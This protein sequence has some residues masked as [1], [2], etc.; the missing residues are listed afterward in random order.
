[1]IKHPSFTERLLTDRKWQIGI[2]L[3]VVLGGYYL[4]TKFGANEPIIAS[5][6]PVTVS[7][8]VK[9]NVPIYMELVGQTIGSVDIAIR[10]RVE[11]TLEGMHFQEGNP[12]TKD[13]PLYTIDPRPFEA[14][15]V[16]AESKVAEATTLLAKAD[17]DLKRVEPLARMNAVSKRDLDAAVAQEGAAAAARDAANAAL[18]FAKL[19]LGYSKIAAPIDGIIG[20]SKAKVGDFVGK[21]PNPVVLNVVS[22][23]DPI[24]VRVSITEKDYLRL[25]RRVLSDRGADDM[26][27]VQANPEKKKPLTLILADGSVHPQQG[28]MKV[29]NSQVDPTTGT[30]TMEAAFPNP[31][32]LLRPGQFARI[33]APIEERKDALLVPQRAVQELQGTYSVMVLEEGNKVGMRQVKPGPKTDKMWV[34]DEGLTLDDIVIVE[35]QQKVR[36]GM[37]VSPVKKDELST[38]KTEQ[39]P[40][41]G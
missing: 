33:K 4:F 10:A 14:K 25:A 32:K 21:P 9:E 28:I 6:P 36:P 31:Q 3:A 30:L 38:A 7:A 20:I 35:G 8:V 22:Q 16:E 11:G 41:G 37:V 18:D 17:S 24:H 5:A 39:S 12:V 26:D 15:V 27:E 34:I 13:Q 19:E 2:A 40:S 23:T 1:M 29:I